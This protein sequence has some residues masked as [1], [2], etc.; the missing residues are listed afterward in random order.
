MPPL[1]EQIDDIRAAF[2]SPTFQ[3]FLLE[4]LLFH[5]VL[6]GAVALVVAWALK[7]QKL[8]TFALII[9]TLSAL[10]HFPH[11]FAWT[12]AA[13]EMR[14]LYQV[15][16]PHRVAAVLGITEGWQHL[17][18]FFKALIASSIATIAIGLQQNQL[19]KTLGMLSIVIAIWTAKGAFWLHN[20]THAQL[21][22][23]HR[24]FGSDRIEKQIPTDRKT[25][26]SSNREQPQAR[27]IAPISMQ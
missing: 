27:Q 18:Y 1:S 6:L 2:D 4:P 23:P 8:Q 15:A 11:G 3:L 9:L 13:K 10:A 26:P 16:E 17:G 25:A 24:G 14:H 20:E 19:G 5:G 22:Q 12:E 7:A 21:Y